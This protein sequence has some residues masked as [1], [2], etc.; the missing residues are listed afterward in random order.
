[1]SVRV[2]IQLG[3]IDVLATAREDVSV[4][5]LPSNPSRAGDRAAAE[6]T[7]I[8]RV[9]DTLAVKGPVKF[10]L[11][12]RGDSVDV[13]VEVPERSDVAAT[14]KYGTA[15]LAGHFGAVRAAVPY[16]EFSLDSAERL[17][18]EGGHG[19]YRVTHVEADAEI[20]F[21]SG[22]V[23]VGDVGG[24]LRLKGS[25]GPI[26]VD[27]VVG[28]AEL[29]TSSGGIELGTAESGATVRSAYGPVRVREAARGTVRID[30]SYGNVEVGVRHGTAVWLDATSQHGV[31]RTDLSADAGPADGDDTLELRLR[32]GYGSIAIHHSATEARP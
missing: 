25:D 17:E 16:G 11:F 12:G 14:V 9:G 23:R 1:M 28:P 7:R 26:A 5:V 21:K 3:R 20:E 2:E 22:S 29:T 30:G 24:R 32:T 19:D 27:R 13:V 10:N 31:V 8:D 4:E 15:R 6:A 18:F